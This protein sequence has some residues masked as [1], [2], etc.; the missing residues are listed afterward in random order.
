MKSVYR[1]IYPVFL[2]LFFLSG[3]QVSSQELLFAKKAGSNSVDSILDKGFAIVTDTAG[4][5]YVTGIM[6]SGT[7]GSIFG[8]GEPNETILTVNGSFLAKYDSSGNLLWAQQIEANNSGVDS[9]AIT[10]D[11]NGNILIAGFFGSEITFGVGTPAET[12][13]LAPAG[14]RDA[15]FAKYDGNGNFLL[16]RVF[17]GEND[18]APGGMGIITDATNNIY[19]TGAINGTV[20]FGL[21]EPNETNITTLNSDIF[22]SK[23]DTNGNL[24][25]A[26]KAGGANFDGAKNIDLDANGNIYITGNFFDT[27]TFAQSLPEET[28]LNGVNESAFIAKYNTNGVLQ[29]AKSPFLQTGP[30]ISGDIKVVGTDHVV[31]TGAYFWDSTLTDCVFVEGLSDDEMIVILFDNEGNYIWHNTLRSSGGDRGVAV[32]VDSTEHIYVTGYYGGAVTIDQ[33][34]CNETTLDHHGQGDIFIAAYDNKGQFLSAARAGSSGWEQSTGLDVDNNGEIHI[35]GYYTNTLILGVGEPNETSLP[36]NGPNEIFVAKYNLDLN[37]T[38]GRAYAGEDNCIAVCEV[39]N[40]FDLFDQLLQNP[41]SGGTW[42]P[43]LSSNGNIYDPN[44]DGAGIFTYSV[45]DSGGCLSDTATITVEIDP[46]QTIVLTDT[47]LD[48]C[49]SEPSFDLRTVFPENASIYD[50]IWVPSLSSGTNIF[51]PRLDTEGTYTFT[52]T[53]SDCGSSSGDVTISFLSSPD[54]GEDG[55]LVL[56]PNEAP[57]NLYDAISGTPDPG[58]VWNPLLASGTNMFDPAVDT[59]GIYQYNVSNGQCNSFSFMAINILEFPSPGT[60]TNLQV[61][62]TGPPV[63]L[64]SL[65]NGTPDTDG[66]WSPPLNSGTSIYDPTLDDQTQYVYTVRN[67][68]CNYESSAMVNI[69]IIETVP[70]T[71]YAIEIREF[72]DNNSVTFISDSPDRYEYSLDGTLFQSSNSFNFLLGGD[73]T[74]YIREKEGCGYLEVAFSILDYP[75]F[76]TPNNDNI[77]DTWKIEGLE[78][79]LNANLYIFDRY[80]KLLTTLNGIET[81]DGQLDGRPLPATDYWF[82]LFL[83]DSRTFTGHFSLMR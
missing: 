82:K 12:T 13:F 45:F 49:D 53:D 67:E 46:Q 65:M 36:A 77:N 66:V 52:I 27:C 55:S 69:E 4:N 7:T 60:D 23:Y 48:I 6:S 54:S 2:L 34:K 8:E 75:R 10:L 42:S 63:D 18:D 72:T 74:L 30:D 1:V 73:Y 80:G 83:D 43:V 37:I 40:S 29:W 47:T 5:I 19:L 14:N 64:L 35:A 3:K 71:D 16:A 50:G 76:F 56:C 39:G 28:F 78:N 58:G 79:Y 62:S 20:V 24:Q 25:W 59:E 81:W 11:A 21:G 22:L 57:F 68:T 26:I 31:Y 41:D 70:I 33:G 32:D 9:N 15:F 51:D 44:L 61:C 17:G 38:S